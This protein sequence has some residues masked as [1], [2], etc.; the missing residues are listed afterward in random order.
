MF[1]SFALYFNQEKYD[2]AAFSAHFI[3]SAN[4]MDFVGTLRSSR[5]S[6]KSRQQFSPPGYG[7]ER[8]EV[9]SQ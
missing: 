1:V 8:G 6:F 2:L 5:T 9:D 4:L 7:R 3:P